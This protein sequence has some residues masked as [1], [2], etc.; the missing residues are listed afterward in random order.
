MCSDTHPLFGAFLFLNLN[1]SHFRCT[2][3]Y[4]HVDRATSDVQEQKSLSAG[5]QAAT[6]MSLCALLEGHRPGDGWTA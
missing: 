2:G 4:R 5:V 3:M 6:L 1:I